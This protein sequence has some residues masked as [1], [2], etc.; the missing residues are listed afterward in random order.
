[1]EHGSLTHYVEW[2]TREFGVAAET[3]LPLITSPSFDVTGTSVFLPLLAGGEVVLMPQEPSHLSLRQLLQ[4]SGATMLNLTPSH[5]DLIGRLD[6]APSGYRS[7]V[8]VGE[9]LRVE[10]AARAQEM[11]GPRCRI[12]NLYG[13]TEATIGCTTHTFR[14]RRGHRHRRTDRAAG[15]QHAGASVRRG[16]PVRGTGRG[17]GNVP[18]RHATGPWVPGPSRSG[19]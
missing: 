13:P 19:P 8:V 18:G 11:F 16:P 17:G 4:S 14:S 12:I 5:L 15:R 7:V 1:M 3:R 6:I 2:A 10:V 9:Q